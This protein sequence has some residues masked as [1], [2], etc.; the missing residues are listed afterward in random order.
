M[1]GQG[2]FTLSRP[3]AAVNV[4]VVL[5]RLGAPLLRAH[6]AC[7]FLKRLRGLHGVPPLG[8]SEALLLRP[9]RA[10]QTFGMP[11]PIDVAFLDAGGVVLKV[12]TLPPGKM[13]SC[14]GASSVV[15]M[16][17]GTAARLQLGVGQTLSRSG[18]RRW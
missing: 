18:A 13:S 12:I 4:P 14:A 6:D 8:P 5:S 15:E 9:C 10:V 1:I 7:T 11:G 16:A 17:E 3:S 2:L